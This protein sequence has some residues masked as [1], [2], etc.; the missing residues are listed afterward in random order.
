VATLV[1]NPRVWIA[2]V[3]AF[4]GDI[5]SGESE[6]I[7]IGASRIPDNPNNLRGGQNVEK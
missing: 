3:V 7:N 5:P 4:A 1:D 6:A 2:V